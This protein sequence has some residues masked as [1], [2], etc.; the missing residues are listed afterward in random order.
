MVLSFT[1]AFAQIFNSIMSQQRNFN[2]LGEFR[3]QT[4]RCINEAIFTL[5]NLRG[6]NFYYKSNV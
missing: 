4:S 2:Y 1:F 5:N 6:K 3:Q